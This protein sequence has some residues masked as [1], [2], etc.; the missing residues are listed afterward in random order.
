MLPIYDVIY[1]VQIFIIFEL[2][3]FIVFKVVNIKTENMR[4]QLYLYRKL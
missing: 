4:Q 2:V 3:S 1:Q